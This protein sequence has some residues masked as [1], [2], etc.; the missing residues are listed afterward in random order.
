M[1][2][3]NGKEEC[4]DLYLFLEMLGVNGMFDEGYFFLVMGENGIFDEVVFLS[5]SVVDGDDVEAV[6]LMVLR[7]GRREYDDGGSVID[8]WNHQL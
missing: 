3:Q 2:S 6:R 8:G 5:E 1:F 4:N 7:M